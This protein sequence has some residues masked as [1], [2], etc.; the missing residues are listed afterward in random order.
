[1][2]SILEAGNLNGK[3]VLVRVDWSVPTQDGKVLDDYQIKKS[4][5][6]IEYLRNAGAKIVLISHAEKDTD[7]LLPI[8]QHVKEY[9][10]LTF[11]EPSNLVLL[12][13]LRQNS[14][15]KENSEVFAR[16]LADMGDIFVNE[17]FP[18]S[19]R[20]HA[21]LVGV[22]KLIPAY[23][24]LWFAKEIEELSRAFNPP[25]P[26]LLI[27][28]GAKSETKIPLIEKF[29]N[30]ADDIFV[31]GTL[32]RAISE[33]PI[34]KNP[35]IAF[36]VG[37]IAALDANK[38]TL[39]LLEEK[40]KNSEFIL[41][42]GPLGNYEKGFKEG[43]LRLA[44]ILAN[45]GKQVVVGGGDTL[46]V[47]EELNILDKFSFVSTGGGAMLDFLAEGTLPGIEALKSSR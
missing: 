34:S 13:N 17:A 45:S 32:A 4:L 8:F 41:W 19:H 3:R 36:P 26:F 14:G 22:P 40:I 21:S 5:P 44:K 6:T 35:K 24:G 27:L 11:I 29:L 37:D 15:E 30:T 1:M 43:T 7:S 25:H 20:E 18:V 23:A 10:P 42:N 16:T 38:E 12:E 28:G 9:L 33:M 2:K 46:A 39:F 31:G 47:I